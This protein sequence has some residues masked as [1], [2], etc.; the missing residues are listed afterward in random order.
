MLTSVTSVVR[1]SPRFSTDDAVRLAQEYYG[2]RASAEALPSE[3][4]QNFLMRHAAGRQFVLKIANSEEA[5]EILDLQNKVLAFLASRETGLEWP[6][7]TPT[8]SGN[9]IVPV[10]GEDGPAYFMRMLTWVEGVCFVRV[11]HTP[12]L[13]ASLGEAIAR[14]DL[15]LAGFEHPAAHRPM[16]W[17]LRQAAMARAHL[18]LL[19]DARRHLVEPIFAAWD[20]I[21]WSKLP[22]SIIHGDA[23]DYNVLVDEA[24]ARVTD[25]RF[26]RHGAHRDRLR[27]GDRAGVRDARQAGPDRRGG[28]VVAAY[29]R[30]RPLT[31]RGVR[32]GVYAGSNTPGD[33]RL[34]LRVA[35]R[36]APENEYLNISNRPAWALL[37][38]LS[39]MPSG[40]ADD[41]FRRACDYDRR[42]ELLAQRKQHLGPSLSISYREPLHIV[43]GWRQ[44]LYDA[45][46]RA[47]LD[48]V[49]NVAHVGHCH[50][51]CRRG[52]LPASRAAQYQHALSARAT[53][54]IR[55]AP[56]GDPADRSAW[57]TWCAVAARRMSLRCDWRGRI[58]VATA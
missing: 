14:T 32:C 15:A 4:D 43:R 11:P 48:C 30:V 50:P 45:S 56:D 26:R 2:L 33:E 22:F 19:P 20:A 13:L 55:R 23:N 10:G 41:V 8:S 16:H 46:G 37:E 24:G 36:Q 27:S 54:G 9:L 44:H 57:C 25:P 7:V 52:D 5:L 38:A 18:E 58:Q 17:D 3:R 51:A 1:N 34:L 49:N 6:G 12:Q 21:D 47:Y 35:G 29:H 31:G 53:R 39:A 28:Q 42:V 40:W